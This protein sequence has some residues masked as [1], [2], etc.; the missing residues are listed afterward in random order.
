MNSEKDAKSHSRERYSRLA[1]GYVDSTS[2]AE[3]ADLDRLLELARPEDDWEVLDVATG[4]GHTALKLAPHVARVVAS[5]LTATMLEKAEAHI[6]DQGVDNI[7]FR[8]ADAEELP[9]DDDTFD[10]VTCRIAPHHF[11]TPQQF[12]REAARVLVDGGRLVVQDH[13]LPDDETAA[14]AI[15]DFERRRDPSH[16]RAFSEAEWI[17]IFESAG[18]EVEDVDRVIKRHDFHAWTARQDNDAD[19]IDELVVMMDEMP[20]AARAW[21]APRDWGTDEA[22]FVNRHLLIAGV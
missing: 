17:D 21:L 15:D 16:V 14:R 8:Q 13:V 12:V 7:D 5:D 20:P 10:L 11:P 22:S 1:Q 6:A 18:L 2:H 9:F 3:G 4:G 19:T